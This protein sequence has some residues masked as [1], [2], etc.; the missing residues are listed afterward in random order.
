MVYFVLYYCHKYIDR[1]LSRFSSINQY[2]IDI[3]KPQIVVLQTSFSGFMACR[4]TLE[5]MGM[6]M[7]KDFT[8]LDDNVLLENEFEPGQ[9]QFFVTGTFSGSKNGVAEMVQK[10]REYSPELVCASF[11]IDHIDG[12][13]DYKI[14][15]GGGRGRE[16]FAA[17]V[18]AFLAGSINR[19]DVEWTRPAK[20]EQLGWLI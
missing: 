6:V 13:F 3:M 5:E 17:A 12:P 4:E 16:N 20:K 18:K 1:F 10:V 2:G 7:D 8:M 15:K 11:A 14:E 19:T 9:R